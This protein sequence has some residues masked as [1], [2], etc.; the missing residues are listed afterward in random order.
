MSACRECRPTA[1]EGLLLFY[2]GTFDPVHNG[3]LAIAR[4][5]RDALGCT[6]RLMPA[7]D[8]PLR[9]APGATAS[10]RA[11]MLALAVAGEPGLCVDRRELE[12]SGPSYTVDTLRE[13]RAGLAG[14]P[15][16]ALL[17]GADSFL[18]LPAWK[19]WQDLFGL[20]HL[21]VA[22]R[23]GQLLDRLVPELDAAAVGRWTTTPDALATAPAGLLLR[24]RQP[25]HEGS[26]TSVRERIASDAGWQTLVP[27]AVAG[28]I[29]RHGLYRREG[30]PAGPSL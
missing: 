3:H 12:R 15:P 13:L 6:V 1:A 11:R 21:V 25:L 7:A 27:A 23:P 4:A 16:V 14:Q 22:E 18:S 28:Y 24:L 17:M 2:G 9:A 26:A 10:D 5:A 19:D 29:Q 30:T 20:A 8:P